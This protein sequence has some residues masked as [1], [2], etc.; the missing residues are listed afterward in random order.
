MTVTRGF[1]IIGLSAF[2]GAFVGTGLGYML[3]VSMPGY[4]RAVFHHGRE[5]WFDPVT[6]G[7]GLGMTQGLIGGLVVGAV[8]VLAV[9]W[10]QSRRTE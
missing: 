4:Y 3:A 8:V 10:Y 1:L 5:P 6:V 9:A 2:V 7:V